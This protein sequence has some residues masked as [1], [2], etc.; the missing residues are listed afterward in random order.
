MA[1]FHKNRSARIEL[2]RQGS[3]M[4]TKS[5]EKDAVRASMAS[6]PRP[7]QPLLTWL[8]GCPL[9][10]Q[11]PFISM[12]PRGN[13][14]M[15]VVLLASYVGGSMW[16]ATRAFVASPPWWSVLG[17]AAAIMMTVSI[18][19]NIQM[20]LLHHLA[21]GSVFAKG[22]INKVVYDVLAAVTMYTPFQTYRQMHV[23]S[24]HVKIGTSADVQRRLIEAY[25]IQKC[26]TPE[27]AL[28]RLFWTIVTPKF[29][30]TFLK[31]K[32]HTYLKK[33]SSVYRFTYLLVH[34]GTLIAA[35]R[36]GLIAQVL[37]CWVLPVTLLGQ[38]VFLFSQWFE[39]PW[40][41]DRKKGESYTDFNRR[42]SYA[43]FCGE[44]APS[45]SLKEWLAWTL[46]MALI[47]LPVRL[48]IVPG[49]IIVHDYHH[50]H[51]NAANWPN[52]IHERQTLLGDGRW[53]H[54]WG[55]Q[56]WLL[57]PLNSYHPEVTE[58]S[59]A[60]HVI[61]SPSQPPPC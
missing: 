33:G 10:G 2:N 19:R 50:V 23:A 30:F 4:L 34:V 46:R 52:A 14:A 8:T 15:T 29:H 61:V 1:E 35:Y 13:L 60:R 9:P 25:D 45:G 24:H 12:S 44:M 40:G 43:R 27:A 6:L 53:L 58:C 51:A 32:L 57:V 55:I 47:H 5:I 38:S 48:L 31:I 49:D 26:T 36:V 21:H 28:G 56:N 18:I 59:G 11:K 39:H 37:V 22:P 3:A 16:C 7:L 17:L 20:N 42:F 41:L 54:S